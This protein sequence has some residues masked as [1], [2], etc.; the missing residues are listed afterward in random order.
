[1]TATPHK[2]QQLYLSPGPLHYSKRE[3]NTLWYLPR[4][5]LSLTCYPFKISKCWM[6]KNK[7]NPRSVNEENRGK[8]SVFTTG[9]Y[10]E[11]N[12]NYHS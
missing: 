9:L 11:T 12:M 5:L 3:N 1:V 8:K 10:S 2:V 4:F 7:R 6:V